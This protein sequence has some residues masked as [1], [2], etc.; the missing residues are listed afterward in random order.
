MNTPEVSTQLGELNNQET[1]SIETGTCVAAGDYACVSCGHIIHLGQ[2][3]PLPTCAADDGHHT[4]QAWKRVAKP[5]NG[6]SPP[7]PTTKPR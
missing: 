1:E 2:V 7:R 4:Q 3:G 6:G 5:E